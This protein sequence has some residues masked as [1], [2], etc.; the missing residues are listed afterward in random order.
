MR[1]TFSCASQHELGRL[2]ARGQS[3]DVLEFTKVVVPGEFVVVRV[4]PKSRVGLF[5]CRGQAG[6]YRTRCVCVRM[7]EI[8][9]GARMV[10]S[11][12]RVLR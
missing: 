4:A 2:Y 12:T 5:A 3:G 11:V 10:G 9:V 8:D 6:G 7:G 1:L